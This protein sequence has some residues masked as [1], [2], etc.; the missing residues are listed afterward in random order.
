MF[1]KKEFKMKVSALTAYVDQKNRWNS[2]FKGKQYEFQTKSGR[3]E[4]ANMLDADLSPENL[5]CDGEL[6]R[7]QI[8]ARYKSL[9]KAAQELVQL[10]PS[11][12]IYEFYTGE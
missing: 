6:S 11:V 10:D 12:R 7:T 1:S 2:I 3:Q 4:I 5:S 9:T 8:N